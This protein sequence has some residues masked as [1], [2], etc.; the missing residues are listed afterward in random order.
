MIY[1]SVP[2]VIPEHVEH[3]RRGAIGVMLTPRVG[4]T[5]TAAKAWPV[6]AADNACFTSSTTFDLP[7][8]LAW[9]DR[10]REVTGCLF[11]TAPDVVGDADATWER[12]RDVLPM[13]RERGY[14]A[15]LVAQNGIRSVDWSAIDSI[16][17]GGDTAFKYSSV[18]D[19]L[20]REAKRLGKWAHMGRVNSL[21]R[22]RL[23]ARVGY[24][25]CD[26]TFI[27]FGP[28]TNLPKVLRW[29]HATDSD[30]QTGMGW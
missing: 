22:W 14:R 9:L 24:D 16:F 30:P 27:R 29:M 20:C 25:S 2:P 21:P 1:L 15:A 5:V 17:I 10:M 13:I 18:A 19:A 7:K 23:C 3:V 26:G 8:Y 28:S 11:A 6:W 4:R 12:S